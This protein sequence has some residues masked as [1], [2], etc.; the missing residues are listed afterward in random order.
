M[1]LTST[2]ETDLLLPLYGGV[3]DRAPFAVFLNRLARRTGTIGAALLY[4]ATDPLAGPARDFAVG[5]ALPPGLAMDASALTS[6][7]P[8]RSYALDEMPDWGE[9]CAAAGIADLRIVRLANLRWGAGWLVVLGERPCTAADSALLTSLAPY[10]VQALAA[11]ADATA[12]A[13]AD[14]LHAAGLERSASGWIAFDAEARV[15]ASG[16]SGPLVARP[17]QRLAGLTPQVDARLA[18]AAQR[19]S[20]GSGP[21]EAVI[22]SQS[23]RIEAVLLPPARNVPPGVVMIAQLRRPAPAAP[24][25]AALL[26]ALF[27]LPPREAELAVALADGLSIKEAANALALTEE[28]ARNYSK[29]LY[30]RLGVRG[31]AEL[32]ALVLRSG[33]NLSLPDAA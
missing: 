4:R 8:G 18:Q 21:A 1:A 28:T 31:Q 7:R 3:A 25:R 12:R 26:A 33:A 13:A 30:A 5:R 15:I 11:F 9:P 19:F 14:A 16:G 22:L 17:G 23:P 10:A 24:E 32:V 20:A 29:K 27:A 2:D 6:L